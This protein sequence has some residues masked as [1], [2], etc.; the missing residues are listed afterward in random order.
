MK[1]SSYQKGNLFRSG[2]WWYGRWRRPTLERKCEVCDKPEVKHRRSDHR[3]KAGPAQIVRRQHSEKLCEVGDRYRTKKDVQPLLDAKLRTVNDGRQTAEG[4]ASI[5]EYVEKNYFPDVEAELKPSTVHGY[6]GLWKMYL[7][8]RVEQKNLLD[9]RRKDARKILDDLHHDHGLNK[10]SLRNCK[11]LLSSIFKHAIEND[12]L[13]CGNPVYKVPI[14]KAASAG[15]ATHAYTPAEVMSLL[16]ALDGVARPA[17]ALM[18]FCG[19]RPGEARGL[20]WEDYDL[21]TKTLHI[22][23]S[24]WRTHRGTPKTKESEGAV[25]VCETLAGMLEEFRQRTF[26]KCGEC[27]VAE[28]DH[29]ASDHE[30][31]RLPKSG[32]ILRTRTGRSVDLQNLAHRV[33]RPALATCGKCRVEE[34]H[35]G[36]SDHEFVRLPK[37]RG[38]YACRRGC[39]TL[40]ASL[41][42]PLAAKSLLRHS[43]L[44]TTTK[45]YIKSV[46]LDAVRAS[47]RMD[48]LF[49]QNASNCSPS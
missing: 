32:F 3:Y 19:L 20:R 48:L 8:P 30:F 38:W 17:V 23:S 29:S 35:H 13:D 41:D 47:E 37:W 7:R 18:Y 44:S 26:E 14:P 16:D 36:A 31:V 49:Q 11:G 25:P 39:A 40:V 12:V 2:R 24:M 9:F 43:D 33:V 28:P 22:S 34:T 42:T 10:K 46:D 21:K 4:T 15:P 6:R 1:Q 5:V 45:H 27:H